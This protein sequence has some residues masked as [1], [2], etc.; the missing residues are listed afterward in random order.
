MGIRLTR[1][2]HDHRND[3]VCEMRENDD[4]AI[5]DIIGCA[6]LKFGGRVLPENS[7]QWRCALHVFHTITATS[8]QKKFVFSVIRVVGRC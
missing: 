2:T 5:D 1:V 3:Q 6:L 4:I 7:G 8:E